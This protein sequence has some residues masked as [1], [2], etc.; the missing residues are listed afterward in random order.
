MIRQLTI[1]GVGLIGGSLAL[2]LKKAG[3]CQH[4]IGCSRREDHLQRAVDLGVIDEYTLDPKA[5]VKTA[6]MILLAVPMGAMEAIF[7][8]IAGHLK[9]GA[10][11]TDAGSAKGS[12]VRAAQAAFGEVPPQFVPAHPI[13]GREKSSVEAA[14]VDLYVGHKV[15]LTPLETTN[16]QAIQ[17]V[18][19][20]WHVAG[21]EVETLGVAQH[22]A[23]LAATSHLPHI[24]AFSFVNSLSESPEHQAIFHY[25]A[26]GFKDFSRIASS[27][28]V[29]WRDICLENKA[30][31][32]V[33]LDH[34][35][36]NLSELSILIAN[37]DSEALLAAF[38]H[39]KTVRD[40][41]I[42]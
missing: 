2:A 3:Y 18:R 12:V 11:I 20:M 21:A 7:K 31:I 19:K 6:D 38:A 23:V 37:E 41:V 22:D 36:K 5:A 4:I 35:Q 14:L 33:A 8:R 13:A 24:L 17:K 27:D 1:F 30:G 28:P 32:L 9:E 26:G 39:A 34:Y 40:R 16:P 42:D 10:V 29:M 25:V 15:I